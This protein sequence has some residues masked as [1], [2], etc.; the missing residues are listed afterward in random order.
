MPEQPAIDGPKHQASGP[1]RRCDRRGIGNMAGGPQ[2]RGA[3]PHRT[4][5][6]IQQRSV[7]FA[8]F[9]R[10]CPGVASILPD[11]RRHQRLA[12]LAIPEYG[13]GSL[14]GDSQCL[15]VHVAALR[16]GDG[17]ATYRQR[18]SQNLVGILFHHAVT[19]ADDPKRVI[20]QTV[21]LSVVADDRRAGAGGT[22]ING[23]NNVLW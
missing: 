7:P 4:T 5:G 6:V 11:H 14:G 9:I 13:G 3:N 19:G 18:H 17:L 16:F 23:Q 21:N 15:N 12:A 22:F 8:G 10:Q 20:F 2:V 1:V